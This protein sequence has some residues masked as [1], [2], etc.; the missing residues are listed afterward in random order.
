MVDL[1]GGGPEKRID[2]K[3]RSSSGAPMVVGGRAVDS[4]RRKLERGS[5]RCGAR[6]GRLS[7]KKSTNGGR[8]WPGRWRRRAQ[9][10]S[11]R[12]E[13]EEEKGNEREKSTGMGIYRCPITWSEVSGRN[14]GLSGQ[15]RTIRTY[16]RT[17]RA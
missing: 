6:L 10:V 14:F 5:W 1:G 4:G 8:R 9:L 3:R 15:V 12:P 13:L 16:F 11:A 17:I 7:R 2:V